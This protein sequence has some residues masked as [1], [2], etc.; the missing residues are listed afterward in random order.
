MNP[1]VEACSLDQKCCFNECSEENA[2]MNQDI[3]EVGYYSDELPVLHSVVQD[4]EQFCT[5]KRSQSPQR[6]IKQLNNDSNIKE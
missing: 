1:F 3:N 4:E 5:E 2:S 6:E